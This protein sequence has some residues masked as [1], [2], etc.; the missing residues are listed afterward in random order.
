MTAIYN[1]QLLM[2][3]K[4][5]TIIK[6]AQ[7]DDWTIKM[8]HKKMQLQWWNCSFQ[9][10][11]FSVGFNWILLNLIIEWKELN[12][13]IKKNLCYHKEERKMLSKRNFEFVGFMF[14]CLSELR[15]NNSLALNPIQ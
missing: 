13:K 7:K 14:S 3:M 11:Q 15:K 5:C 12:S 2:T 9:N 6:I 1:E 8:N 4:I 10:V